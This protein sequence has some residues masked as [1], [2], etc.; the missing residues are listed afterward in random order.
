VSKNIPGKRLKTWHRAHKRA[1]LGDLSL[2]A[3]ARMCLHGAD[4]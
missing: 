3:F 4:E 2:R 1:G